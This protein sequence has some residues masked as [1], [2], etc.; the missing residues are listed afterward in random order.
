MGG[1]LRGGGRVGRVGATSYNAGVIRK[2]LYG[3]GVVSLGLCVALLVIQQMS[4]R[5][6]E[7]HFTLGKVGGTQTEFATDRG[8]VRIRAIVPEQGTISDKT[9]WYPFQ[10]A[11]GATLMLPALAAAVV[12][13]GAIRKRMRRRV[14]GFQPVDPRRF[15]RR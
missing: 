11:Y 5:G 8:Q 9:Q 6:H 4:K 12:V 7:S 15:T 2:L 14:P 1:V 13:R 10:N 3:L